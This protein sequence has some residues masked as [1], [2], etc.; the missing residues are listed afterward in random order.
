VGVAE[1]WIHLATG[2]DHLPSPQQW[3][4]RAYRDVRAI[5]REVRKAGASRR[6]VLLAMSSE[7]H[8]WLSLARD[9]ITSKGLGMSVKTLNH[10]GPLTWSAY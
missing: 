8:L 2:R 10:P 5:R 9:P 1:I 4:S 3:G 6:T 7:R